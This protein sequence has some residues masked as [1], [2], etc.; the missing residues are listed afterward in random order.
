ML[1]LSGRIFPRCAEANQ[2]KAALTP[3]ICRLPAKPLLVKWTDG[4]RRA[5]K[6]I[7]SGTTSN[8]GTCQEGLRALATISGHWLGDRSPEHAPG[9][10]PPHKKLNREDRRFMRPPTSVPYR[11]RYVPYYITLLFVERMEI[12]ERVTLRREFK[13][14][15]VRAQVARSL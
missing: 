3:A 2:P 13:Q 12:L 8:A 7:P 14:V 4:V 5:E 10:S 9:C 6:G 15:A 1:Q 11:M